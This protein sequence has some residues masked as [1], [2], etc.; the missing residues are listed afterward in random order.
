MYIRSLKWLMMMHF[1]PIYLQECQGISASSYRISSGLFHIYFIPKQ[2]LKSYVCSLYGRERH[3]QRNCHIFIISPI[4]SAQLA[5]CY[6]YQQLTGERKSHGQ[7]QP[8]WVREVYSTPEKPF[9]V[10]YCTNSIYSIFQK[11]SQTKIS[12]LV[13]DKI[14][15]IP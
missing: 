11:T 8:Q 6:F 4:T 1:F 14:D 5:H 12:K 3:L 15:F 7:A 10:I 9:N 13:M 2:F